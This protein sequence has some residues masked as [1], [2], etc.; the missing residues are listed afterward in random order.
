MKY[1]VILLLA[2]IGYQNF[3][4]SDYTKKLRE[5]SKKY[6]SGITPE[7]IAI[8]YTVL[9]KFDSLQGWSPEEI[10]YYE[11]IKKSQTEILIKALEDETWRDNVA[12]EMVNKK[13]KKDLPT[14]RKTN[15]NQL[16]IVAIKQQLKE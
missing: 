4:T 5:E 9:S 16:L 7:V 8:K 12:Y 2:F 3:L 13:F 15:T 6:E 11:H 1:V 10:A 14:K